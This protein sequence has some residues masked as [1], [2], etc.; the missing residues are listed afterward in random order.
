MVLLRPPFSSKHCFSLRWLRQCSRALSPVNKFSGPPLRSRGLRC[1]KFSLQRNFQGLLSIVQLSRFLSFFS[2]DSLYR[3]SQ[4]FAFVKNF[5]HSL[6]TSFSSVRHFS[7]GLLPSSDRSASASPVSRLSEVFLRHQRQV[8]SY[9]PGREL[10]T[11][12]LFFI[13]FRQFTHFHCFNRKKLRSAL[14][15]YSSLCIPQNHP[16]VLH[17]LLFSHNITNPEYASSRERFYHLF[18]HD[19]LLSCFGCYNNCN[20]SDK[21]AV[22]KIDRLIGILSLL[23]QKETETIPSL[24]RQFEV[25]P[26]TISRDIE[27]LCQIIMLFKRR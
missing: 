1:S 9:H 3:L 2:S 8:L 19:I 20:T 23:L 18:Q 27:T 21:G 26:R 12:F 24:A 7:D 6:L 13:Y 5:F 11:F 4:R 16:S 17:I 22:M 25:S 15:D 14:S 10:S